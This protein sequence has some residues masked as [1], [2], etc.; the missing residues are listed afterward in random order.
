MIHGP[1]PHEES[2][3]DRA[4]RGAPVSLTDA[5]LKELQAYVIR[6]EGLALGPTVFHWHYAAAF[7]EL[8]ALRAVAVAAKDLV[9]SVTGNSLFVTEE[10]VSEP[11]LT[12]LESALAA[13]GYDMTDE[14]FREGMR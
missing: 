13:A 2:N 6:H 12:R 4:L 7:N 9:R 11:A 8:V 10:T 5:R 1:T 3:R 14:E